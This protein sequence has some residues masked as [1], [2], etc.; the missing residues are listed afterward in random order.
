MVT[1]D[2]GRGGG[3]GTAGSES[4]HVLVFAI[5][6]GKNG[7]KPSAKVMHFE[8]ERVFRVNSRP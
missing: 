2:G 8:S 1:D 7:V 6:C 3:H 4:L 5:N